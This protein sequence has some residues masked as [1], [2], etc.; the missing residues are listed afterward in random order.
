[1]PKSSTRRAVVGGVLG[2]V[3]I[4]VAMPEGSAVAANTHVV[5]A[6]GLRRGDVIMGPR[7]DLVWIASVV[8]VSRRV[9]ELRYSA[10]VGGVAKVV[11]L[12]LSA[13]RRVLV[14]ARRVPHDVVISSS[15]DDVIEGGTP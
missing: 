1:M 4:N 2:A 15:I 13:S 3:A 12:R 11:S 9:R 14:L 10:T 5:K 7:G 8:R 6:A